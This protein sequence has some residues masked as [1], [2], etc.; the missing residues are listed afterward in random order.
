M[1]IAP[2]ARA[3][4]AAA[5]A[6]LVYTVACPPYTAAWAAWIVPGLLLVPSRG[7]APM[8]AA[9][10]GVVFALLMGAGVTGWALHAS[11]EY[12]EFD[13]WTAAL[14]V[15]AVWLL[16]G[17]IPFALLLVG[18]ARWAPRLPAAARAPLAAW[19]WAAMELLRSGLFS[20]MP[21][22]LL[23][24]T[25]FRALW[26][27]QIADIGGVPA[28]S[29]VMALA[30]V[31]VAE[32]IADGRWRAGVPA[33]L[34]RR[35]VPTAALVLV[36]YAYGVHARAL[37]AT[38]AGAAEVAIGIVQGNIPNEYRWKRSH[39]E[40]TLGTYVRLTE[41]TRREAPD[42]VVWPENAVD[43]YFER[44][45]MLRTQLARV[46]AFAPGGLLV[47]SPRLAS[48]VDARNSAQLLG[49]NG[50][51]EGIYDKQRLVPLAESSLFPPSA[52]EASEPI[53][54]PGSR[55]QPIASPVGRLGT[56]I[57]Y[58]VLFPWLVNDLVRH[59]AQVLVNLSNDAW[60]DSGDGAAPEQHFSMAV[61]T[62][63]AT[64]RDLVRAAGSGASGVIDAGGRIVAVVPRNTAGALVERVRLR[65]G[66]S[67]YVRFGDAWVF[68][69]GVV[70]V[71]GLA[72]R[73][74]MGTAA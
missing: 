47:G 54:E 70:V 59:G 46:A 20:G 64:R 51:V 11:L 68:L 40:R 21:W 5:G 3:L 2:T 42:L 44:E 26:L 71:A 56:M 35:L 31:A 23:G 7:L 14:F 9:L 34:T 55:A 25:Q 41:T 22:E 72:R 66:L 30:S 48:P 27:I 15:A 53:Y 57:C 24:H 37:Y 8:R 6:A 65:E 17:G 12:F 32:L 39:M 18:Y 33:D 28:V 60:L 4:I 52:A 67:P 45:P 19:G 29:F 61:F 1:K 10:V 43:F 16:Y 13:R 36:I 73:R 69:F 63:I 58:E 38:P 62:A 49:A 74:T 50:A